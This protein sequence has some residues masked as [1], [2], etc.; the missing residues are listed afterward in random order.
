[1]GRVWYDDYYYSIHVSSSTN[2]WE[3]HKTQSQSYCLDMQ[4]GDMTRYRKH[5]STGPASDA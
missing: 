1:M 3:W 2:V 5:K 4:Q